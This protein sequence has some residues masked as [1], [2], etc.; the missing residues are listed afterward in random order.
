MRRGVWFYASI[1]V[2]LTVL[3]VVALSYK[4]Q[5][6]LFPLIVISAGILLVAIKLVTIAKPHL[7]PLLDP[8]GFFG[9]DD[10]AV[11]AGDEGAKTVD[12]TSP[13]RETV[14]I[15]WGIAYVSLIYLLG[16]LVASPIMTFLFAKAIGRRSGAISFAVAAAV[17]VF[18]YIVFERLLRIDLF[19]GLVSDLIGLSS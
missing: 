5:T 8:K 14:V 4:G 2:C 1:L 7:A 11:T 19:P 10:D 16:F 3:G 6:A 12:K 17:P 15:A 9:D 13:R 18:L